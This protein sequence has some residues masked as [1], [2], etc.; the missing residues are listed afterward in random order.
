MKRLFKDPLFHFLLIGSLLFAIFELSP[1]QQT[2]EEPIRVS[3]ADIEALSANFTRTWQRPPTE[4]E[5]S[6]LVEEKVRDEIAFREA[7]AM[8]LDQEDLVIRRRL[9]MKLELL[10]EDMASLAPPTEQD[11]QTFLEQNR[12]SFRRQPMFS[13]K[14]IYL[15]PETH[16]AD[17][18]TAIARMGEQLAGAGP[19]AVL[20]L[21]GDA[22]MLPA[23]LP[24]SSANVI[25]RYFGRPFSEA[26]VT[27]ETGVWT[28]PVRSSYG[29]HFVYVDERVEGRD[30]ELDEVREGVMREWSAR[31]RRDVKENTYAEL[32]QRYSVIIEPTQDQ[33]VGVQ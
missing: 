32:R 3:Q 15:N 12:D 20:K 16:G 5:L 30:P 4:R 7:V 9:R 26:L 17:T 23:E 28:G 2:G 22:T 18:E 24:L 14:Q 25:A 6:G 27:L 11:L 13:V 29:Y 31:Q 19:E 8:G 33:A 21:K 10:L 1:D